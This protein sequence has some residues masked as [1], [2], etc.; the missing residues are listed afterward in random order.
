MR[1][2]RNNSEYEDS[3]P[4]TGISLSAPD[5]GISFDQS[6]LETAN[7]VDVGITPAS[8][9]SAA[10]SFA[11]VNATPVSLVIDNTQTLE[12]PPLTAIAEASTP[13]ELAA[14]QV[15]AQQQAAQSLPIIE[16]L[17]PEPASELSAIDQQNL[18]V[19]RRRAQTQTQNQRDLPTAVDNVNQ[20]RGAVSEPIEETAAR[21]SA[22]LAA[23]LGAQAQPS[24]EIIALC[25][26][27]R[28]TIA[29]KRP[30]DEDSLLDTDPREEAAAAGESLQSSVAG[31]AQGVTENYQPLNNTPVGTPALSPQ[32]LIAPSSVNSGN[33][34]AT[35]A[36]PE[37]ATAQSI[38]LDGDVDANAQR[39]QDAGMQSA[40]ADL[41]QSG[42]IAQGREAQGEL[43]ET[44]ARDPALVLAEQQVIR[45]G[46]RA[47]MAELQQQALAALQSSRGD[48][49]VDVSTR[50]GGMVESEQ[51]TRTRISNQAQGIFDTAQTQV[52]TLLE[53][54]SQ[55]ATQRWEAGVEI[56]ATRFENDLARI[57]SWKDERHEGIGGFFVSIGDSLT[58]LPDW[59][60][61][62]YDLAE[63]NFG[64]GVCTLLTDISIDVNSVIA[65]CTLI[66]DNANTAI[67]QLF[68]DLPEGLA[69]W[70]LDEQAG[71]SERLDGLQQ[72]VS[73]TRDNFNRDLAS[74]ASES[75]QQV[76]EQIHELREAAGGLIGRIANAIGEFLADPVKFII[77]GLLELVGI[78]P[79]AFWALVSKIQSV[80]ADI[81]DDPLGFANNLASA[82]G[83]GFQ[84][85]FDN[86]STHVA[87]GFFEWLF[88]GLGS[89][90]VQIPSDLQPSSLI[91]FFLQ[92]MGITWENI[93]EI[94]ARHIG[95]ENVA[96]L[97]QA[98]ELI[99][100]LIEQGPQGIFEMLK[101][102]LNPETMLKTVLDAAIDYMIETLITAVSTRI[103]L[104][105]NPAGAL[106]Q[107]IEVIYRI[108]AWVF[109]NAARIFTLIETVVNGAAD[110]IAGNY[111]AMAIAVEGALARIVAPVIDF[112]AGFLG[113]GGLPDAIADVIKSFQQMVL[114]VVER[115][116][117]W[118]ATKARDLLSALGLGEEE[119]EESDNLYGYN[120][121]FVEEEDHESHSITLKSGSGGGAELIIK[122]TPKTFEATVNDRKNVL[123]ASNDDI[124]AQLSAIAEAEAFKAQLDDK[125]KSYAD[126]LASSSPS[127]TLSA[128]LAG[129]IKALIGEISTKLASAGIGE[130]V[131][132]IKP[133]YVDHN[134]SSGR[135]S[136]VEASPLTNLPGNTQGSAPKSGQDPLGWEYI[137]EDHKR[138]WVRAHLLNHQ[139][140]GPGDQWNLT[141]GTKVTNSAMLHKIE[142]NVKEAVLDSDVPAHYYYKITVS[143]H[144]D[145]SIVYSQYYP[146]IISMTWGQLKEQDGIYTKDMSTQKS[147]DVE[148]DLPEFEGLD[149]AGIN[150][151]TAEQLHNAS[152]A[153]Q[154]SSISKGVFEHI[155]IAK[156]SLAGAKFTSLT[157]LIDSMTLYYQNRGQLE[158]Y[159]KDR[160]EAK[161]A[162]LLTAQGGSDPYLYLDKP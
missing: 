120:E 140:H 154:G 82:L 135:A 12:A 149:K 15:P 58:G 133:T 92:L 32:G 81:A 107:A 128:T 110:L 55:I 77:N 131:V 42:P 25:D 96:L 115:V 91:T 155:L 33:L 64:D 83:E 11:A 72:E 144:S 118:L 19:S 158:G 104:M 10:A 14:T 148:Q 109:N 5:N 121:T 93:R 161:L 97:E 38:S 57:K 98:Y 78:S 100:S 9:N 101:E 18:A 66:I 52:H 54:L 94:L 73:E 53:P 35:D 95:E 159:F 21:A 60:F 59:F 16:L 150:Q 147:D 17:M 49:V 112:L 130:E 139:L 123:N 1:K 40:P 117:A 43:A 20:S 46:T 108:L 151:S 146:K 129:D 48:T 51:Q 79:A 2:A 76:R 8:N 45:D 105:F 67:A 41:V 22:G 69:Q 127:S 137:P 141:P 28:R 75:V 113:L 99:A 125:V 3:L 84:Q 86:F 44:A 4:S 157:Q 88:S 74:K 111:T 103:I 23:Q 132:D 116:V 70:A 30:P 106:V 87:N 29:D 26:T 138:Y 102:Q 56:L 36:V 134:E 156:A 71:F 162:S 27:I 62:A 7:P 136:Y 153:A 24:P 124:Q 61:D 89:V 31:Q 47:D 160:Y 126:N 122:S 114:G 90:G 152:S 85:F 145:S 119:G 6:T 13:N 143:Y 37:A 65:A 50:Q 80:M 39:M 34:N 68:S 63:K 142:K